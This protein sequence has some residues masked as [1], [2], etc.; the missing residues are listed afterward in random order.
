MEFA[1]TLPSPARDVLLP[2][3][4][5]GI[6]ISYV[7]PTPGCPFDDVNIRKLLEGIVVRPQNN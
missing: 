2:I 1:L 4:V 5:N 7:Q 3:V 6:F